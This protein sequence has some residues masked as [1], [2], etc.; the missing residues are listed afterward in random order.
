[1]RR[2]RV[3]PRVLNFETSK[4]GSESAP[5]VDDKTPRLRSAVA[6]CRS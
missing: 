5:G 1:M 4:F 6:D 3:T 2:G